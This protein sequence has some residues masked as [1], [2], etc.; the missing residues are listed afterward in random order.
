MSVQDGIYTYRGK[1]DNKNAV[2]STS[3]EGHKYT[4]KPAGKDERDTRQRIWRRYLAMKDSEH[5]KE[6]ERRWDLGDKAYRMWSPDRDPNDWRADII[7]PD[8]FSAIQTHMQ[9]ALPLF[10]R[11]S[12]KGVESSDESLKFWANHLFQ[13]AMD[14]TDFDIEVYKAKNCSAIRGDAYTIEE[15]R[16][17]TREVQD[18]ISVK[19]GVIEYEKITKV[20]FDDVYTRQVDNWAIFFDESVDDVKYAEDAIYREVV[21]YDT[22]KARYTSKAGFMNT[23]EVVPAG[24]ISPNAGYFKIADDMGTDDVEILH[25]Y[26]ELTDSYDALCNN[27][28]IR[29]GPLPSRHKKIPIDKWTFYPIPGQY[30][31][32]GIPQIMYSLMEERRTGRNLSSDRNKMQLSKMFFVNDLFDID[33]DDLTPRP[34]GLVQVNT[35]GLPMNQV[36]M[37]LEYGDVPMSSIRLDESLLTEERRAHGLD[38]RPAQTAGGTATESAIISEAAQK[39]INLINTLQNMTTLKCIGYKKWSNVQFFYPAKR[40]ERILQDNKYVT[41]EDYRTIPV[42]GY[43]FSIIG[44]AE[45]GETPKLIRSKLPTGGSSYKLDPTY[46]KFL[47]MKFDIVVTAENNV[48]ANKAIKR[49]EITDMFTNLIGNPM[50]VRYV[51]IEKSLK[52]TLFVNDE[53]PADWMNFEGLSEADMRQQA[54]LENKMIADM[55]RTGKIFMLPGTP[56]ARSSHTEVHLDFSNTPE[57]DALPQAVQDVLEAHV[58]QEHENNPETGSM[59]DKMKQLGAG[60]G[61]PGMAEGEGGPP[62]G[63]GGNAVLPG[64]PGGPVANSPGG[65]AAPVVGGDVTAAVA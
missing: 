23:E 39:R 11:P 25:Y 44:K 61:D 59:A 55:A 58:A 28:V 16:Y 53:N 30:F 9:E 24:S 46:A 45:N 5:R 6:A 57:F 36:I 35:N 50:L 65:P 2:L 12:L 48:V 7:L 22:F 40:K 62:Q 20:D 4:Y 42:D 15:Y 21:S 37:P 64:Q 8:A 3:G 47:D 34:H 1:K 17:E 49:K 60:P 51:D 18:P 14:T 33:E 63:G 52:R 54:E 38:D 31:G 56:G 32:L 41:T 26:N 29:K 19:E 27:V 13:F 43:E 10:S